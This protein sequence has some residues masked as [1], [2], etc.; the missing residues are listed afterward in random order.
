MSR[1]LFFVPRGTNFVVCVSEINKLSTISPR[2]LSCSLLYKLCS[3]RCADRTYAGAWS[4]CNFTGI[5]CKT[6]KCQTHILHRCV[7][8]PCVY[9]TWETSLTIRT[10]S[11]LRK[12]WNCTVSCPTS[13]PFWHAVTFTFMSALLRPVLTWNLAWIIPLPRK[14]LFLPVS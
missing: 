3:H 11:Q 5:E 8:L 13:L 9:M 4:V 14:I 7:V 1:Y 2:F 10:I 6:S 12:F